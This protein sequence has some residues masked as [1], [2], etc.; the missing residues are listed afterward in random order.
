MGEQAPDEAPSYPHPVFDAVDGRLCSKWNRNRVTSAQKIEGVPQL[1]KKQW[2]ALEAFDALVRRPDLAHN[3]WLQPGDLQIINSHVTLHSRTDFRDYDDPAQK[4]L[5]FRLWLA[6]QDGGVL[7]ESWRV[8]Y[9]SVAPRTVLPDTVTCVAGRPKVV[10][11]D[12]GPATLPPYRRMPPPD[13]KLRTSLP[14]MLPPETA[15]AVDAEPNACTMTP[16]PVD[17]AVEV[18]LCTRLPVTV[19]ELIVPAS[20]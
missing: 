9:K 1:S 19:S 2:N 10:A 4:R 11:G 8:L 13:G 6:P 15:A 12:A 7:P 17:P 16:F 5:L 14:E 18:A 3:M 20:L